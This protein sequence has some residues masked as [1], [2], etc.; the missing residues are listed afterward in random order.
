MNEMPTIEQ[1]EEWADDGIC[2][3][4]DG[5]IVEPDGTCP[6]G[7]ESWLRVLGLI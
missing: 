6:H 1:L 7:K 4:T 2:E 5:C 3:A